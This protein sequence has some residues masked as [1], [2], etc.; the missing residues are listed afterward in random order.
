MFYWR[1]YSTVVKIMAF[2]VKMTGIYIG[3]LPHLKNVR[4][5]TSQFSIGKMEY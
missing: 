4:P 1:L 2:E 3:T 5:F